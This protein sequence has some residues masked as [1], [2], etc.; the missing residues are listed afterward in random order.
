M[1]RVPISRVSRSALV[2][3][4]AVLFVGVPTGGSGRAREVIDGR[5]S[6]DHTAALA[7]IEEDS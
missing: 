1:V 4:V 2:L 5:L 7:S 6:A 3:A